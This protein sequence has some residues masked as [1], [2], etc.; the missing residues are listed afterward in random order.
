VFPDHVAENQ[1][2]QLNVYKRFRS[3]L[4]ASVRRGRPSADIKNET[5]DLQES[6]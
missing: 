2:D 4:G 6:Y 1:I 5:G 3:L